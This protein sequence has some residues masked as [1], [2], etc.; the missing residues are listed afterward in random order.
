M[1]VP[2][3]KRT[4]AAIVEECFPK[5]IE[6][7]SYT[8]RPALSQEIVPSDPHYLTFIE[9][10]S[11]Y[12]AVDKLHFLRRIR[13]FLQEKEQEAPPLTF[14]QSEIT[15]TAHTLT[16]EQQAVVDAI[17]PSI[18]KGE[19]YPALLHGVTGAGKTEIYKKLIMHAWDLNKS[20]LLLL[21]EVSL[22]VQFA[23]LLK[24]KLPPNI[25]IYSF[26]SAT[27]MKEKKALWQRLINNQPTVIVGVHIP[28]L[29]PL[30]NLGLILIDEEHDAG[31]QEKKHPKVHTKEAA[32]LRAQISKIPV[33]AGSATPSISSLFNVKSKG[34]HF[35]ELKKRFA[36]EFPKVSVIK[37]T[38][39]NPR[40]HFWISKELERAIEKQLEKKEQTI[41]FLN[42]RGYSFF[43]QC[44]EC[45]FIPHCTQCSVSLTLHDTDRLLCHYCAFTEIVP[46]IC[47]HCPVKEPKKSSTKNVP[48]KT[49]EPKPAFIKQGIGTQQ[50]VTILEKMYPYAKIARADLD[51]TIN[52]KKWMETIKDFEAGNID[53]LVGTQTITKG[54]HFP[55]VTL[56]GIL[57]ADINLHMPMYNAAE[58]TLQQLIQVAGRAGRQSPD[59]RVIVQT[60]LDHPIYNYLDEKEYSTFYA[61]EIE[62]RAHVKYPPC[63]RFA[64]I[65]LRNEDEG[66]INKEAEALAT[67]LK[68]TVKN[69][70]MAIA[71]LGPSIPPVH[72]IKKMCM[73]KIY[74]KSP[75]VAD[76]IA[77]YK[78]ID[79]E[80]YK[81][82]IL[83]T[84][85]PL[86]M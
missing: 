80:K 54:Y 46:E 19:Y 16:P 37:L 74:L 36:G 66:L 85:N 7:P 76:L 18:T 15:F 23:Q 51:A 60:M 9:K 33:L 52:K 39:K 6:T 31:Y 61:T 81:S 49:T 29:V 4:E 47:K 53:I 84:Q 78:S 12:H 14:E 22:A 10:L 59:S 86:S 56:V 13:H 77:L 26:H 65:E 79:K 35:F 43:V 82:A 70:R 38:D 64:E 2:L 11:A 30:P 17:T 57:W 8:I 32:F 50:V 1:E 58:I 73:R 3:Q 40:K 55:H 68:A 27:S 20:S 72:M 21:P 62:K 34:W 48:G 63:I 83:F 41:V 25:P 69:N 75:H 42:R 44:R 67:A 71:I 24:N 5:L 28:V 45:G